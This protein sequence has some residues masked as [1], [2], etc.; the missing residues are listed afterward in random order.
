M[1]TGDK[2]KRIRE[3]KGIKQET[4][5]GEL[6][7]SVTQYGKLERDE[8]SVTVDRLEKIASILGVTS[9]DILNFSGNSSV[10]IQNP[11]DSYIYTNNKEI[12]NYNLTDNERQLYED[13]I[14]LLEEI[15]ILK[16]KLLGKKE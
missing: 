11:K 6:G 14:K 4:M 5:A 3:I 1:T 13:K 2:I 8:A 15:I 16:D 9:E 7:L 12:N 10:I